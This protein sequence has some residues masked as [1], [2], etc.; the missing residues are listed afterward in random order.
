MKSTFLVT[1]TAAVAQAKPHWSELKNYTFANFVAEFEPT[2]Q[3]GTEEFSLRR[4]IFEQELERVI[5]HNSRLGATW[6]ENVNHMSHL[7][8]TEKKAFL[9]RTKVKHTGL[10]SQKAANLEI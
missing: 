3:H 6:K 1:L 9:G 5:T 4:S 10:L 7:T 8:A 2:L